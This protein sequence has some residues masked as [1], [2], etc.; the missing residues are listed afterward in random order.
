MQQI[1]VLIFGAHPDDVEC[2]VAGTALLLHEQGIPFAIVDLT[3]GEM[4][5]RG[6][7]EERI[8]EAEK[9]SLL[10]GA[11]AR[12]NLDLGDT[13]LE[14]SLVSRRQIASVIRR[15][16]PQLVLA[17]YWDDLHSDH[18]AAGLMIRN[19][20]IYCSL[21]KLDD[22][23]PPHKPKQFLYYLLHKY[24]DP[25]FIV[26]I[27]EVFPRKLDALRSYTSQFSKTATEYGVVPVGIGDYLF[28]IESRNRYFGSLANVRY[29]EPLISE[30]PIKL[31][32]LTVLLRPNARC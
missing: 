11:I 5:S 2:G 14:D 32:D 23:H 20:L 10:L 26:D 31:E 19:S 12:E 15:Y 9:S 17:P 6:T 29:G 27:S 25:T 13:A 18:V 30:H 21:A 24:H 1:D 8:R 7:V 3:K 28:H 16:R 22:P 4:G